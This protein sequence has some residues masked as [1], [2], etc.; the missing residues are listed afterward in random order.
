MGNRKM[1]LNVTRMVGWMNA[2]LI[3]IGMIFY[4]E[5]KQH[6]WKLRENNGDDRNTLG[7]VTITTHERNEQLSD[8]NTTLFD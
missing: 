8:K 6:Y 7:Q 1:G 4:K 3:Y 2:L 5:L